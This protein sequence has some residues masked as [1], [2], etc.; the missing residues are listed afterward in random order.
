M[1]DMRR[2]A[3]TVA[4]LALAVPAV[5][6]VAAWSAC[7]LPEPPRCCCQGDDDGCAC[8]CG[9][10]R[11]PARAPEPLAPLAPAPEQAQVALS[12]A[13]GVSVEVPARPIA[14]ARPDAP[15]ALP[16]DLVVATCTFRC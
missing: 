12:P 1:T 15:P 9:A 11:A 8:G 6:G 7:A 2:I 3:A 4:L 14:A 13:G 10:G 5:A 16:A